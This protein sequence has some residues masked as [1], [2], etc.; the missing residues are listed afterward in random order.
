MLT[1]F[2][3]SS[4]NWLQTQFVMY[5]MKHIYLVVLYYCITRSLGALQAGLT[6]SRKLKFFR[7]SE[8][9]PKI[10]N[11]SENLKIFWKFENFLKIWKFSENLKIYQKSENFS[12]IWK[13]FENLM[14]TLTYQIGVHAR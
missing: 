5:D 12:K 9:F 11:F 14:R 6:S 10:W 8:T 4:E 13:F 2:A 3:A 1:H 7:K